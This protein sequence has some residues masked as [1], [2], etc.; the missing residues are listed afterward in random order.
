MMHGVE[1]DILMG[2]GV[3]FLVTNALAFLIMAWDKTRS[4]KRGAER[5]SEGML[6][7][8]ATIFGSVGVS[9]GMFV[10]RHKTKKWYFIIG[11]PLLIVQNCALLYVVYL[12]MS[13]N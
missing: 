6:F 7:F 13:G 11:I 12:W 5:I 9:I 8:M 1:N 4:R 10:L 2:M 3:F